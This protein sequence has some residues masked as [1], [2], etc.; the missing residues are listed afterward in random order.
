MDKKVDGELNIKPPGA[1]GFGAS[2]ESNVSRE[3]A[4]VAAPSRGVHGRFVTTMIVFIVFVC[5]SA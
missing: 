4:A 1:E 3:A 2:I 5:V